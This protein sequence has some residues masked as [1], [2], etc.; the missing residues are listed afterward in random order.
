[1]SAMG[2]NLRSRALTCALTGL[3]LL[4][5][6]FTQQPPADT[7]DTAPSAGTL[8]VNVDVV[9]IYCNVKDKHG[10][11]IPGLKKEDFEVKEDKTSQTVKYF[12]A[13]SNQPLTLGLL[14][15]TSG[16]MVQV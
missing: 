14:M 9:N 7:Q 10:A 16:S 5:P 12:S 15:D 6:A 8:K 4:L 13:E 3:F 11:L 2:C 1:M